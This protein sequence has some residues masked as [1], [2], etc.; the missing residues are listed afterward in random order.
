MIY[1]ISSVSTGIL[2][3]QAT[4]RTA[5][6]QFTAYN[7]IP[8]VTTATI[9]PLQ[10]REVRFPTSFTTGSGLAIGSTP[11]SVFNYESAGSGYLHNLLLINRS[12]TT[13][14]FGINTTGTSPTKGTPLG[15]G[16]SVLFDNMVVHSI[17]AATETGVAL[18]G[19]H[20][21]YYFNKNVL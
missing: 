8:A 4:V 17:W 9:G 20:G 14:Y 16:E 11:V 3:N 6:N 18:L 1:T 7:F 21:N 15:S 5:P 10:G 13:L 2:N 12:A 19:C